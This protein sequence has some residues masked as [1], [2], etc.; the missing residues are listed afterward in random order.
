MFDIC[1]N[2]Q[3]VAQLHLTKTAYRLGEAVMGILDF[4]HASTPTFEVTILLESNEVVEPTIAVRQPQQIARISRKCYAEHHS[5][6]LGHQR[7]AFSLPIPAIA[8]PEFQT[9]GGKMKNISCANG[10]ID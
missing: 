8:S 6:S 1:K 2:N 7:L 9:T 3:R 10:L 4:E 5:F